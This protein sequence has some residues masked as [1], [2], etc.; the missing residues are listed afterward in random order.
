[1]RMIRRVRALRRLSLTS[2]VTLAFA[3][4]LILSG[5]FVSLAA[6]AYGR[7]AA[8][9][10]YDRLL[11]GAA[12]DIAASVTV[13]DGRAVVDLPVS[14]FELLALAPDDRIA[15]R[16][17]G[18]NGDTLTGFDDV[19]PPSATR[20]ATLVYYDAPFLG[21][22]AR[23]AALTRR[24]AERSLSG[25]VQVIVGQTVRAREAL[26]LD[27]TRKALLALGLFGAVLLALAWLVLRQALKPLDRIGAT[28]TTRDP[29]D[30]T[31]M[32]PDAPRE[33]AVM[34]EALNGFMARL[35]RQMGA[36]RSLISDT[37]HQLR[38]PVAALRAQA[39]LAADEPDED[40]RRALVE[41]IHRRSV[42]LGRLLDQML[43]RALVIH[44]IDSVRREQVDLRDVALVVFE[45]GDH[46]LL[47]PGAEVRLDIGADPVTVLGDPLSL[48]EAARNLLGNAL[49]HGQAPVRIGASQEA[50]HGLLWVK[51]AGPGP[52]EDMHA[53][54]FDRF[55]RTAASKGDSAGL[56]LSIAAAVAEAF[57]GR[58]ELAPGP[59]GFRAALILPLQEVH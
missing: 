21:E 57:D 10:A 4:L 34:I 33:A 16:V 40:R 48:A 7:Q 32:D 53:Q 58:L 42:A 47:A 35:D 55:A 38:T 22:T 15:Y 26:A 45:A 19:S 9:E 51:D 27:L 12:R 30:L 29:Y 52:A 24:F 18:P 59:D 14:A 36:M 5:I 39:D 20:G 49:K 25:T 31:P 3:A 43:S 11:V 6:F 8:R 37:A 1:M 17:I 54:G 44:R 41:R 23:Y 50:G 56:G 2:R 46:T 28:L 13:Q